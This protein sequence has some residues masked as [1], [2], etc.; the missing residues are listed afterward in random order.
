[1]TTTA[2]RSRARCLVAE[3]QESGRDLARLLLFLVVG[4]VASTIFQSKGFAFDGAS[5]TTRHWAILIGVEKYQKATPLRFTVNDVQQLS[6]TLQKY[7]GYEHANIL[8]ITDAGSPTALRPDKQ[9]IEKTL[10][11]WLGR[12]T[13][14]DTVLVYFSGHGFRDG[15]GKL[16]LAPIDCNPESPAQTAIP[17]DWVREQ[18]AACKAAFKLLIID[19]C[20]AGSEK[21]EVMRTA[22]ASDLGR[23]FEGLEGVVT[24]ASSKGDEKSQIWD[25]KKRSLFSYWLTQGLKG[26]ADRDSNGS[27]DI[28]ELYNYVERL[29]RQ[30]AENRFGRSQS[31]VR[32]VR[33]GI[34]GVPEVAK[35]EAQPLKAA[36]ADIAE[37]LANVAEEN[38]VASVGVLEFLDASKLDEFLGA[39]FGLLGRY[40][41]DELEGQLINLCGGGRFSVVDRRRLRE[42]LRNEQFAI[43]DLGS[44][45]K[46]ASLSKRLNGMPAIV[47]GS[48]HGRQGQTLQ[49]RCEL[50]Q[51]QGDKLLAVAGGAALLNESEWAMLGL[52]AAVRTEDRQPEA[53]APEGKPGPRSEA[54]I[55]DRMDARS[56]AG[57]VLLDPAFPFAVRI[58][59]NGDERKLEFRGHDCFLPVRQGETYSIRLVNKA[60]RLA[61]VRLLVDGL[62]TLPE[63][64]ARNKGLYVETWAQPV[65]NLD[66]A[67]FWVLDPDDGTVKTNPPEWEVRGFATETGV[68]GTMREFVV[69]DAAQSLAGRRHFTDQIG[70]ITAA[71][72]APKALRRG[73][74]GTGAGRALP[75]NLDDKR[76]QNVGC[77]E[78]LGVAH[79]RCV[80]AGA[81]PMAQQ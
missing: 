52:S 29:V 39:D 14:S 67:R 69:V 16:Y 30:T 76:N 54:R 2:C 63:P 18:I 50:K 1:M 31:P 20:H 19:A 42:A 45:V 61:L 34:V 25:A 13:A 79:I 72:Y 75:V 32:I 56:Q 38:H 77:G 68:N 4:A 36:L 24:L 74:V 55:I 17:I 46:L 47:V 37:Q 43:N 49:M 44:A 65:T 7:D 22:P 57:H 8:E 58:F 71:F 62:N 6:A 51:T 48:F 59:V 80:D 26:H 66:K 9:S 60:G 23:P 3:N 21:G 73:Q 11:Q 15:A 70:L 5:T 28:D 53:S 10:P 78:L 33:A 12:L 27:V 35:L 41:A 40:C 64:A 81:L